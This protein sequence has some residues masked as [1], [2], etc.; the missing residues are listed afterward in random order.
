[1]ITLNSESLGIPAC[2]FCKHYTPEGRRG[3][4]CEIFEVDVSG[5]WQPCSISEP[6]FATN[7]REP[8]QHCGVL[9][10]SNEVIQNRNCA[11]AN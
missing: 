7:F 5:N 6:I 1:M 4:T 3:G 2:R 11:E 10:K 8:E 9:A